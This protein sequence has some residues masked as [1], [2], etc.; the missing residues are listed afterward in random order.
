VEVRVGD[1][2]TGFG[3]GVDANIVTASLRAV[4]CGVNR[5]IGRAT[6]EAQA[7]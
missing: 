6:Q 1:S 5:H 4:V 3:A 2:P 7:A